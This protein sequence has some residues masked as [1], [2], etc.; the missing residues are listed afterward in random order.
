[1]E[2]RN[3]LAARFEVQLN[4]TVTFDYPTI[5]TLAS[6]I[7]TLIEPRGDSLVQS[8]SE[9]LQSQSVMD[10]EPAKRPA[11]FS[12]IMGLGCIY[13]GSERRDVETFWSAAI[14][15]KGVQSTVPPSR[16]DV[17]LWY[18]PN[19]APGK[20]YARFGG[21]IRGIELFDA[22][23][24]RVGAGEAVSLDPQI[25]LLLEVSGDALSGPGIMPDNT[26]TYVGCMFGDYMNFMRVGLG[27]SH[28][29]PMMIGNG[30]PY[31]SGRVAYAYGLRGPSVGIDTACSSSLI[32]VHL[33]HEALI[34]GDISHAVVAGVNA[35]IWQETTA[36]ICQLQ[37]LSPV[38]RCKTFD[39]SADGYG[40]GEGFMA[41]TLGNS[42]D[43]SSS[44]AIVV[45]SAANS[46]G[47]SSSLTAPHGP[48]QQELVARALQAGQLG[49]RTL[50]LVAVHGTGTALGDPIEV[51]ALSKTLSEANGDS[52]P[53]FAMPSVKSFYGHTE[54]AAGLTGALYAMKCVSQASMPP[55]L[56]L[57]DVNPYVA[58]AIDRCEGRKASIPR[59]SAAMA[60]A[61]LAGTSSF[62]MSG[63]NAHIVLS[64]ECGNRGTD[65]ANQ[66]PVWLRRQYWPIPITASH[67]GQSLIM[68]GRD[69]LFL[70]DLRAGS[71]AFMSDHTI[72]GKLFLYDVRYFNKKSYSSCIFSWYICCFDRPWSCTRISTASLC[73]ERCN[74]PIGFNHAALPWGRSIHECMLY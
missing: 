7:A 40:R 47:R 18:T 25:R 62:G 2:L 65:F 38:G 17:D 32:A 19:G 29:G 53:P 3:A 58:S 72:R 54:G 28:S 60:S 70:T 64:A 51:G 42:C 43:D 36:G 55:V 30:A 23:A 9:Y 68:V 4:P 22:V 16:W 34:S 52:M 74:E 14:T 20:S 63:I 56:T 66:T 26:G 59:I 46:D 44:M 27:I 35:M 21:F 13:P 67:R 8:A 33:G 31:Q 48:S 37:A 10:V 1:M 24:F 69:A 73:Y 71:M 41:I 50:S 57:R 49:P 11:R 15:G 61:E 45:G 39:S 12:S 5:K 6:H